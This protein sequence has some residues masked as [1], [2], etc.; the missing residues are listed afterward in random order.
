MHRTP[1]Q[2]PIVGQAPIFLD[3][4]DHVSRVAP[5][6]RPVL[7]I[8]ERGTG[9]ELIAARMHF[10][11]G[12][13]D[14]KYMQ[15]NCAA[16]PESLLESELFGHEVGAFTG[17]TGRRKGR[18]E[19]ADGGSLLLDEIANMSSS[20]Q[21]KLLRVIEYGQFERVGGDHT[22]EVDVRVIGATNV[23][24][25]AEAKAG[26]FRHDLLD[27]LAF[28]VL[29]VPP[30]RAR[31]SD[32]LDLVYHFAQAIGRELERPEFAGFSH[33]V[34]K[35]FVEYSWPG[36]VRELKNVVERAV[37]SWPEEAGQVDQVTFDPFE[38]PWRPKKKEEDPG[39]PDVPAG[40][41]SKS[42][43]SAKHP[44]PDARLPF[45]LKEVMK[46]TERDMIEAALEANRYN[47]RATAAHLSLSYDQL[48]HAVK[49]HGLLES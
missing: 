17:A 18:F 47:Q 24:L 33:R 7:I 34:E 23:D 5:L 14:Q 48:R 27:R 44:L 28:D 35:L 13:W 12:R 32:I 21:E 41:P 2:Y 42:F 22:I 10:L 31:P 36:N 26:R 3:L 43:Q 25:P 46:S 20:V 30:L 1:E 9:K 37:Y 8:G 45:K 39:A 38:S 19:L 15:L 49:K 29:T 40:R 4:L 16:L 11:S 6:N